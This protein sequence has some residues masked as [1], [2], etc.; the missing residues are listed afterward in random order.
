VLAAYGLEG[1]QRSSRPG[2]R[3]LCK[4]AG[5]QAG[6]VGEWDVAFKLAPR[7]NAAGRLGSARR[8]V[9]LLTTQDEEEA[10]RMALELDRENARRQR[11]QEQT[12]EEALLT[13]EKQGGAEGQFGLV[14]AGA[15]WHPGVV[16]VVAGRLA[17]RFSRPTIV[18]AIE[19]GLGQGSARSG[20]T[21]NLY[22]AL[23]SC[24]DILVGFGGHERA[25][26]L[27]IEAD[28]VDALRDRFE[29]ALRER[30]CEAD[31]TARLDIEMEVRLPTI[32]MDLVREVG[33]LAPFG[34]GNRSP[35]FATTGL[36][37]VGR[38][39]RM[40][41]GGKHLSF[42]VNQ[43][44]VGLRALAFNM[45]DWAPELSR[46]DACSLAYVPKINTFRGSQNIEI[47]VKDLKIGD[48][49]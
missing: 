28:K 7:L 39:R 40:G 10:V 41:S 1:L 33:R 19:G 31:L 25:A 14:V 4:A 13:I 35:V 6:P 16:G 29:A 23:C 42:W 32:S 46:C 49:I 34:E 12:L 21:V 47:Q 48:T 5:M 11:I 38:P 36:K 44:G 43:D 26:G 2:I 3:A 27:R 20:G 24:A 8:A 15:Q 22:E 17:E 30:V 37:V 9:D 18:I 45:G